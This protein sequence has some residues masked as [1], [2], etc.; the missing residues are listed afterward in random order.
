MNIARIVQPHDEV[1][2]ASTLS[3]LATLINDITTSGVQIVIHGD[4]I[5]VYDNSYKPGPKQLDFL[6]MVGQPMWIQPQVIQV[7]FV[8][9]ADL[10]VG[11][12]I[13]FPQAANSGSSGLAGFVQT[14]QSAVPSA[15]NYQ[16]AI[17]GNFSV[18]SIRHIGDMRQPN[19]NS[20]VTVVNAT[21]IEPPAGNVTVESIKVQ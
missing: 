15:Q 5:Q 10:Q 4:T 18:F 9:R 8:M 14:A 13:S 20:W 17:K 7:K 3:G 11:D 19:G 2:N 12:V 6:D 16:S 21:V 1:H